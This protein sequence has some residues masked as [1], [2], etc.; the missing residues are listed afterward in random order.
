MSTYTTIIES[1]NE[2]LVNHQE[3]INIINYVK[4]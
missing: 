1:Y 2:Y 3:N 4:K